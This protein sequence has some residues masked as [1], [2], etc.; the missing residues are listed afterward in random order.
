MRLALGPL[1]AS[2]GNMT[3]GER[4]REMCGNVKEAGAVESEGGVQRVKEEGV[5]IE[6]R[7]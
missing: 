6:L 1:S 4:E 5:V 7:G 2:V 3:Q